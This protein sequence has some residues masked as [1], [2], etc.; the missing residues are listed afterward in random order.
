[1]ESEKCLIT[2]IIKTYPQAFWGILEQTDY[3]VQTSCCVW[4]VK[5]PAFI[6]KACADMN[7]SYVTL[8]GVGSSC[9]VWCVYV[10]LGNSIDCKMKTFFCLHYCIN[11][12]NQ[13]NSYF[14]I[15]QFILPT[16]LFCIYVLFGEFLALW[17][18]LVRTPDSFLQLGY[19]FNFVKKKKEKLIWRGQPKKCDSRLRAT[20]YI[21]FL[22]QCPWKTFHDPP[23][24]Y[25]RFSGLWISVNV[26]TSNM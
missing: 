6:T 8:S 1:M 26:K 11:K 14:Q 16:V 24:D 25:F 10:L 12:K 15:K 23:L 22:K 5:H 7:Q 21:F 4:S 3:Q 13:P 9:A 18:S 17:L 20:F 19:V 2:I